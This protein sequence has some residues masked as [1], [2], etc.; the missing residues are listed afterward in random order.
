M[1]SGVVIQSSCVLGQALQAMLL[2]LQDQTRRCHGLWYFSPLLWPLLWGS[3]ARLCRNVCRLHG[4]Y[5]RGK[6]TWAFHIASHHFQR[7]QHSITCLMEEINLKKSFKI[8]VVCLEISSLKF[9]KPDI[10]CTLKLL[11]LGPL[12]GKELLDHSGSWHS[13]NR[14]LLNASYVPGHWACAGITKEYMVLAQME[15][16]P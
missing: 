12:V 2:P 1:C 16:M 10:R 13:F 9:G 14:Y 4:V 15:F 8:S 7:G 11:T 3:W 5:H 6:F